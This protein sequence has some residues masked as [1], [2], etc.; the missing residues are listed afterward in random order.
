MVGSS[1]VRSGPS[2]RQP[3]RTPRN[4][5]NEAIVEETNE[6][7]NDTK[8][9][10]EIEVEIGKNDNDDEKNEAVVFTQERGLDGESVIL[11]EEEHHH[12]HHPHHPHH[13]HHLFSTGSIISKVTTRSKAESVIAPLHD[14]DGKPIRTH[15]PETFGDIMLH[16][17]KELDLHR[18]RVSLFESEK[19][20]WKEKHKHDQEN[21]DQQPTSDDSNSNQNSQNAPT[22][23]DEEAPPIIKYILI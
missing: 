21:K 12:P 3:L 13:H 7:L 11:E 23:V 2:I 16:P 18:R 19:K 17:F 1:T 14:K 8:I 4:N 5:N 20:D 9:I 15:G 10:E 22:A 6:Q